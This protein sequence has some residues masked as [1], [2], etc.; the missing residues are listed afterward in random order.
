MLVLNSE[1]LVAYTGIS[2]LTAPDSDLKL[3]V[4]LENSA[5]GLVG[6]ILRYVL[7]C[8]AIWLTKT[9]LVPYLS[10][11]LYP[12]VLPVNICI[13]CRLGLKL[14]PAIA[15]VQVPHL[16][17][18]V[19]NCFICICKCPST[20]TSGGSAHANVCMHNVRGQV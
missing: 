6:W 11:F 18:Q 12:I 13:L 20:C 1:L 14:W 19:S 17:A 7:I 8:M 3:T 10:G 16:C 4:H 5:T 9:S 15:R 2:P